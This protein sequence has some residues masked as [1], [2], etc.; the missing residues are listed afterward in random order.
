[1]T[2]R[3]NHLQTSI[4]EMTKAQREAAIRAFADAIGASDVLEQMGRTGEV[5]GVDDINSLLAL[6]NW[7]SAESTPMELAWL[8]APL[9]SSGDPEIDGYSVFWS[10][11]HDGFAV[12]TGRTP[13]RPTNEEA[14]LRNHE[15][16]TAIAE[17][18]GFFLSPEA[19]RDHRVSE[20][21]RRL[22]TISAPLLWLLVVPSAMFGLLVATLDAPIQEWT[23]WDVYTLVFYSAASVVVYMT[24]KLYGTTASLALVMVAYA[25]W[26][27]VLPLKP[28]SGEA[29]KEYTLLVPLF[30]AFY[31][32]WFKHRDI[33]WATMTWQEFLDDKFKGLMTMAGTA[34]VVAATVFGAYELLR[35]AVKEIVEKD[36]V[37]RAG[38]MVVVVA[39]L[40]TFLLKE[41]RGR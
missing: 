9:Q 20:V 37:L 27:A 40:L 17:T 1:M 30:V 13:D 19:R 5:V 6:S 14:C 33:L 39:A 25:V 41:L 7:P 8:S 11:T 28:G 4:H 12:W 21:R 36:D 34:S 35:L 2:T 23:F 32:V 38:A 16:A 29:A 3:Q 31:V 10:L 15:V 18:Y 24:W 26:A 22:R